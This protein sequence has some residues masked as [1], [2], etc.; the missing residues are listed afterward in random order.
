M[1][2]KYTKRQIIES[3][4]YWQKQLRTGNYKK[5]DE[6][7]RISLADKQSATKALLDH[8]DEIFEFASQKPHPTKDQLI[9]FVANIFKEEGL[10]TPWTR[11]FL[12]KM[13]MYTYGYD[14]ALQ[15]LYNARLKGEKLGMDRGKHMHEDEGFQPPKTYFVQMFKSDEDGNIDRY[16]EYASPTTGEVSLYADDCG[17]DRTFNLKSEAIRKAKYASKRM[18][19]LLAEDPLFSPEE[20]HGLAVVRQGDDWGSEV[21]ACFVDGQLK[22]DLLVSKQF[23]VQ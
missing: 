14:D 13:K 3:I 1:Q 4:K 7:F 9:D 12:I 21:V 22:P 6:S 20:T 17:T 19:Q 2:R 5:I 23:D 10:D 8:N 18:A 16:F 11:E 15:Y